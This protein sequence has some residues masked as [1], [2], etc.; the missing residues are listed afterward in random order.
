MEKSERGGSRSSVV[1]VIVDRAS[2]FFF[3]SFALF[4]ETDSQAG[5][6]L[7]FFST[8]RDRRHQTL[9][10]QS[11][12]RINRRRDGDESRGQKRRPTRSPPFSINRRP[13][14][15]FSEALFPPFSSR[16]KLSL[17]SSRPRS[18]LVGYDIFGAEG[19][20]GL[21]EA[22][23]GASVWVVAHFG[24][25]E[26]FL[27]FALLCCCCSE[28]STSR[29]GEEKRGREKGGQEK[30][31][32]LSGKRRKESVV[33]RRAIDRRKKE[34]RPRLRNTSLFSFVR[35]RSFLFFFL[36]EGEGNQRAVVKC[37]INRAA[38]AAS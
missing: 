29:R 33:R 32:L 30:E 5:S 21:L 4:L 17:S 15:P 8:Q 9:P 35:S 6:R 25:K 16:I 20:A 19:L 2:V 28:L 26:F 13:L 10:S 11:G 14:R 18:Y 12:K 27:L 24:E 3:A 22:G 1:A 31:R 36:H 7:C 23:L 38:A 37:S 34:T